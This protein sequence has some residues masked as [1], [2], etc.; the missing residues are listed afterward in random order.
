MLTGRRSHLVQRLPASLPVIL[1]RH[2][3]DKALCFEAGYQSG[4]FCLSAP[5]LL[6]I[7]F[8]PIQ[9]NAFRRAQVVLFARILHTFDHIQIGVLP[10]PIR[11]ALKSNKTS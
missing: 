11:S 10:V 6:H 5:A 4:F 2:V 7:L 8:N 1:S 3:L 9:S